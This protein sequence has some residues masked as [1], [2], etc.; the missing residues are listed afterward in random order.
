MGLLLPANAKE[1]KSSSW[2]VALFFLLPLALLAAYLPS[3]FFSSEATLWCLASG[4]IA[5]VPFSIFMAYRSRRLIA[6]GIHPRFRRGSLMPMGKYLAIWLGSFLVLCSWSLVMLA[7][8]SAASQGE[9]QVRTHEVTGLVECKGKCLC[10]YRVQ[11]RE[12]PQAGR[13]GLCTGA[14]WLIPTAM[15]A[16]I[17]WPWPARRV[18]R[19][20]TRRYPAVSSCHR[21]RIAAHGCE[22]APRP[23]GAR[24]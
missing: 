15:A 21:P 9:H 7:L 1:L 5:S 19:P 8:V 16:A 6:L 3:L 23:R 2:A 18:R 14:A 10:T 17:R 22:T 20:G 24:R 12:F 4:F 11:L 13:S